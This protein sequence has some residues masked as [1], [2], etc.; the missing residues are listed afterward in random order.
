MA[1]TPTSRRSLADQLRAEILSGEPDRAPGTLVSGR[2]LAEH[3]GCAR[4]TLIGAMQI[5]APMS[6]PIP[7]LPVQVDVAESAFEYE[8]VPGP[9]M[10]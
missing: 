1:T 2:Q 4:K 10:K 9:L 7:A 3:L 5:L 6:P 8:M